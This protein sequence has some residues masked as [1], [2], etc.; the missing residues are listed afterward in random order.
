MKFAT[1]GTG[2]AVPFNG[3]AASCNLIPIGETETLLLDCGY[4]CAT[5]LS[6]MDAFD[7]IGAILITHYHS[8]HFSDLASVL[9][10]IFMSTPKSEINVFVPEE[11]VNFLETFLSTSFKHLFDIIK[12]ATSKTADVKFLPLPAVREQN[13]NCKIDVI[14][15]SHGAVP[16]YGVLANYHSE[17]LGFSSDTTLCEGLERISD[18]STHLILDCAFSDDMAENPLHILPSQ[19]ASMLRGQNH[20]SVGLNHLMPETAGKEARILEKVQSETDCYVFLAE[21]LEYHKFV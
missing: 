20:K 1:V 17:T 10:G 8:D 14:P 7:R 2:G 16:T 18:S 5:N 19:I 9:F 3:K 4:G 11:D 15:V 12:M 21:D 6:K 13:Y